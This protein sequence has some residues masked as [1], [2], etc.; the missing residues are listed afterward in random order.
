LSCETTSEGGGE[1]ACPFAGAGSALRH[2]QR[3]RFP[4]LRMRLRSLDSVLLPTVG[5]SQML[6]CDGGWTSRRDSQDARIINQYK[7]LGSGG[8]FTGQFTQSALASGSST[9]CIESLHDGLPD[10]WKTA[11]GLSTSDPNLYKAKAP[12]GYTWLENYLNGQ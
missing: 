4:S 9:S 11:K 3:K 1:G 12:N 6:D 2:C 8:L 5:N 7:T 10:Q